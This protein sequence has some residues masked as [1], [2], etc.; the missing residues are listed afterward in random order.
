AVLEKPRQAWPVL[1][2]IGERGAEARVRLDESLSKLI[3]DPD[4][5]RVEDGLAVKRM[6]GEPLG[7]RLSRRLCIEAVDGG[8]VVEHPLALGGERLLEVDELAP[9]VRQALG[10][11]DREGVTP[12]A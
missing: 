6:V 2:E 1:D 9:R 12:I 3:D 7:R 5:Q 8:E 10:H 4:V 11:H